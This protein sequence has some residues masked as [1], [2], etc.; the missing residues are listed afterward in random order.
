MDGLQGDWVASEPSAPIEAESM[1]LHRQQKGTAQHS[2][3]SSASFII[4]SIFVLSSETRQSRY[5]KYFNIQIFFLLH[6]SI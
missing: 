1:L 2:G 4:F 3:I 6:L 5:S